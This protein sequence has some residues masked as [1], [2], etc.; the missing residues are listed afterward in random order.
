MF[1][2]SHAAVVKLQGLDPANEAKRVIQ[3]SFGERCCHEVVFLDCRLKYS[4]GLQAISESI[5]KG[6]KQY[7]ESNIIETKTHL[8][9]YFIRLHFKAKIAC[10][11]D[12]LFQLIISLR[13]NEYL[14][15]NGQLPESMNE[16]SD[17]LTV[18]NEIG[19]VLFLTTDKDIGKS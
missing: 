11:L 5:A 16:L 10:L 6:C 7:Q 15:R 4:P 1:I 8:L 13:K 12:D 2:A 17:L 3:T 9:V 18:L 14:E 19:E